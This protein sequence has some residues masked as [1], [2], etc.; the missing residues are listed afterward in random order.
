MSVAPTRLVA[1]LDL[2]TTKVAA[3]IAEV[4]GRPAARRRQ[5][6]W[7]SGVERSNGVRRGVV[8][9]I[10]ETTRAIRRR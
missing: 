5:G 8:R 1:A 2:G 3:V 6:S 9:D 4:H 7:A 10:E